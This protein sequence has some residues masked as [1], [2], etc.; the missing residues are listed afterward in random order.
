MTTKRFFATTAIIFTILASSCG[1]T[2]A[3]IE[4]QLQR[5][6]MAVAQ[7]DMTAARSVTEHLIGDEDLSKLPASQLAR[8]SMV[9][10][11]IADSLDQ[12]SNVAIATDLYRR[13]YKANPDSAAMYYSGVSPEHM[14][15]ATML[16]TLVSNIDNPYN[17]SRD[18][19]NA[20]TE[21]SLMQH[22]YEPADTAVR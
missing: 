5:A 2:N 14:Q 20:L 15:Y 8:L 7:G 13:A 21:D 18:S 3:D 1:K 16:S 19:I 10:M 9:Y 22:S 6:E 11:Q 4:Q 12:N 17:M